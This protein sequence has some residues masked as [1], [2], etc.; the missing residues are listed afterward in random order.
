VPLCT[1]IWLTDTVQLL[2]NSSQQ[3][4]D[5]IG[6]LDAIPDMLCRYRVYE[7]IY[8][9]RGRANPE[10]IS[11][12]VSFEKQVTTIYL[13]ILEYQARALCQFSRHKVDQYIRDIV[14]ADA[15]EAML[16]DIKSRDLE[17]IK[18][19]QALGG[20]R[21]ESGLKEQSDQLEGFAKQWRESYEIIVHID[22]TVGEALQLSRIAQEEQKSAK[23]ERAEQRQS[24]E[25]R[26]C[27]QDF[28]ASVYEEQ[29][30]TTPPRVPE[31]CKWFLESPGFTQ[32]RDNKASSLLWV[33]AGPGCGKS[34]LSG[35]LVDENLLSTEPATTVCYFFFKDIS[36]DRRNTTKALSALV[37][38]LFSQQP[39]LVKY[40]L[41]SF[42]K[43]GPNI[44][45]LFDSMCSILY[46]AAIDHST[47]P[48]VC[49]LDALDECD[50][51][52][53][54]MLIDTLKDLASRIDSSA[55]VKSRLKFI[56]TSRPYYQIGHH[57][58]SLVRGVPS[59]HL[60]GDKE[61][62]AISG[63][64]SLV[65]KDQIPKIA[66]DLDL[67]PETQEYLQQHLLDV[68]Q[69]TYLW[70]HLI[71]DVIKKS[72]GVRNIRRLNKLITELPGDVENAYSAILDKSTD[73]KRAMKLLHIVVAAT[74]PLTL[75][76]MA[77]A[78]SIDAE[79]KPHSLADLDDL[80]DEA[81]FHITVQNLCGL[82]VTIVDFKI[83]LIHQTA[84][85]FLIR[86]AD[87]NVPG[88][89]PHDWK[90]SLTPS[91]SH[92]ILA[93][94]C[95]LYL[96]FEEFETQP[97]EIA[98]LV[99]W[100]LGS[101]ISNISETDIFK[102][103]VND[104]SLLN[105]AA[106]NWAMHFKAVGVKEDNHTMVKLALDVCDI[107]SN[108]FWIW[109]LTYWGKHYP[110]VMQDPAPRNFNAIF[111]PAYFGY[112]AVVKLLIE[113]GN[114][115][116]SKD[117]DARTPLWWAAKNGHQVVVRLL[118]DKGA[119]VDAKDNT[120]SLT[121]LSWAARGGNDAVVRLLLDKGAEVNAKH[122]NDHTPL[123]WAAREGHKA[124]VQLLLDNGAEVNTKNKYNQT[125][126]SWAA[127]GGHETVVQLLLD[128]G[129]EVNIKN[130]SN[131]TPLSQAAEEG[132]EA[133]VR[134]LLDKGAE[135]NAKDRYDRTPLSWAAEGGHKTVVQLLLDKGAEANA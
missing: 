12:A 6:G 30:K 122:S 53:R 47:P 13:L 39:V 107:R 67:N 106:Q 51:N 46:E 119:K 103:S 86:P 120:Y 110:Y 88:S 76:E 68:E 130:K 10:V 134:L 41:S 5:A 125:P 83:Y 59:V 31:T 127:Q 109:F 113:R 32:W 14:K 23:K 64:I 117:N 61:S 91:V 24:N 69:R 15:W 102:Q 63:E 89:G 27:I 126:L 90:Y 34:V 65:I 121:P 80:E 35:T 56:V 71:L 43:E 48:V 98:G 81:H 33:S 55:I 26:M 44:S 11:L 1:S 66:L 85:E 74:R 84:K 49:L 123:S 97:H 42:E 77:I 20:E 95:M 52:K 78:L 82:F 28:R 38:Q 36:A 57:F 131:Q 115:A 70:L 54:H 93:Q 75:K 17:C 62:K 8:R 124:V 129:A 16:D 108:R 94:S 22:Q 87:P 45:N 40:C 60:A 50:E 96:F 21:L 72:L 100:A 99:T 2:L 112:E 135:V 116:D 133:V 37:H 18:S 79:E 58:E 7:I 132:H 29:K 4:Q 114:D 111:I 118:L 92:H 73:R 105:Y 101:N 25:E 9:Q 3:L 104:H 19:A 128:K